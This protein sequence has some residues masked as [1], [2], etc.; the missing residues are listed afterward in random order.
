MRVGLVRGA[1]VLRRAACA[2]PQ[3]GLDAV[4]DALTGLVAEVTEG[5]ASPRPEGIGLAVVGLVDPAGSRVSFAS[6]VRGLDGVDVAAA[7]GERLGM[8]AQLINDA[9][10]AALAEHRLG[11]GA[12][13]PSL[14]YL[15]ISTGIGGGTCEGGHLRRGHQGWASEFGHMVVEAN[16]PVC[17][18]GTRGCLE[19]VA[20]GRAIAGAASFALG[21]PVS[22]AEAFALAQRGDETARGVVE[23]AA[24]GLAIG[25]T[26]VT[27]A[28]DPAVIV[29]GG[30]VMASGATLLDRVHAYLPSLNR[31]FRVPEVLP[32]RF[33]D[34]A[35]L[36]GAAA[37]AEGVGA[38]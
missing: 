12:G 20:S 29:L 15:T 4:L 19:A 2:T 11:A 6:N 3:D 22:T 26:N 17:T 30:G 21:R 37:L 35:G 13:Y 25:L 38:G 9:H 14:A 23:R 16:G 5:S 31:N 34:D 27:R 24:R 36:I 33:G 28:L 8:R 1:E 18:C 32:A 7:A 10:A